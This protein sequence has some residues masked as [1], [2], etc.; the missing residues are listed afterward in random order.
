M[1]GE[2]IRLHRTE[3]GLTQVQLANKLGIK[4][5]SV[6]AWE[7]GISCPSVPYLVEMAQLFG[8]STDYLLGLKNDNICFDVSKLTDAE[9]KIIYDLIKHF[10]S[11]GVVK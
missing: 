10:E 2:K 1:I 11:N 4:R 6:N 5:A 7:M 8:V 9:R 3:M